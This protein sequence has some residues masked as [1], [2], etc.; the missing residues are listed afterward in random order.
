MSND[1][2]KGHD[3]D[4]DKKH[5]K[6]CEWYWKHH[7]PHP[8][9][10]PHPPGP[11][12]IKPHTPDEKQS[13]NTNEDNAMSY[14]TGILRVE[15]VTVCVG[16]SDFLEA[17]IKQNKGLFDR[18]VI[19]T[20]REDIDTI[21]LCRKYSIQ[22]IL[23]NDHKRDGGFSKG[24]LIE[25]GLQHLSSK[26]WR[27]HLDA[28][29]VLPRNFRNIIEAAHLHTENLYGADRIM[30]RSRD[31]WNKLLAS[32][33]TGNDYHCRVPLPAGLE[34]GAR[35]GHHNEGY[36]PIGFFQM[37]HSSQDQYR[38][39]RIRPYPIH[40]N[41]AC[42]TDVQFALQWDRRNRVLIPEIIVVHL[43]SEKSAMGTNWNGRKTKKF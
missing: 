36:C 26:G 13:D 1:N 3:K 11:P 40:H 34:V 33:W 35:W 18:W 41:D 23:S 14:D 24:R 31:E 9:P 8:Q 16:Y 43:E 42:R 7:R 5:D 32:G 37:W 22:V 30:V 10:G 27:I 4:K 17:T 38:G 21:E 39:A 20:S 2:G 15:A 29:I 28:D 12:I 19:V 6:D 25:R